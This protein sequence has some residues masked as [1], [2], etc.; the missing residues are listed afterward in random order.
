MVKTGE[1]INGGSLKGE[2][3]GEERD[4]YRT[5]G[6]GSER[7]VWIISKAKGTKGKASGGFERLIGGVVDRPGFFAGRGGYATWT[8]DVRFEGESN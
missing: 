2:R 3:R 4:L 5:P 8:R 7:K 6:F 1:T